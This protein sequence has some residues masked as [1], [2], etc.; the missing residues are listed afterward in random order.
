MKETSVNS[1]PPV[2]PARFSYMQETSSHAAT[3]SA[4]GYY[5]TIHDKA[6]GLSGETYREATKEYRYE[7]TA[8]PFEVGDG[9]TVCHYSDRSAYTVIARTDK[10]LTLRR[11]KVL[12][13]NGVG[14][15]ASDALQF[16]PGGFVGHTSGIQ[17]YAY[18]SDPVGV[19]VKAHLSKRGWQVARERMIAGRSEH[20]DL[21]F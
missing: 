2:A 8:K 17:R 18:E 14:S 9:A 19:V 7:V 15:G 5:V 16:A 11:D 10:T 13:M 21:N 3:L 1:L 12:L 6:A 4:L 20:Y